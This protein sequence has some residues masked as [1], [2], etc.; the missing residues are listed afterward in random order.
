MDDELT[1]LKGQK[2]MTT[3]TPYHN[4]I[5]QDSFNYA[6]QCYNGTSASSAGNCNTFVKSAL[7]FTTNRNASC[8]FD[9][10]ICESSTGN[11]LLDSGNV[12][13]DTQLGL[14]NIPRF[15]LR[16]TTHCAPLRTHGYTKI[17]TDNNSGRRLLA[18]TYGSIPF[19]PYLYTYDLDKTVWTID[20]M[21]VSSYR[22]Q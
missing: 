17:I 11:L 10:E 15:I 20:I 4:R 2:V 19:Q 16:Y 12:E 9:M 13:S 5:N 22:M 1:D 6:T 8:P 7:P 18:Y 3:L 21:S 14:N